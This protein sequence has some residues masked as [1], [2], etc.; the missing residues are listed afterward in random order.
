MDGCRMDGWGL[1]VTAE[2]PD[3]PLNELTIAMNK[4]SIHAFLKPK[5]FVV[6]GGW[7][8]YHKLG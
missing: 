8:L 1:A 3:L 2:I 4:S 6:T 7:I 5:T